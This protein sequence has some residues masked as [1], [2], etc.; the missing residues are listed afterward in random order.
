MTRQFGLPNGLVP[1][2]RSSPGAQAG[3]LRDCASIGVGFP[4]GNLWKAPREPGGSSSHRTRDHRFTKA[5]LCQAELCRQNLWG[6]L[7]ARPRSRYGLAVET[8]REQQAVNETPGARVVRVDVEPA[9]EV[10]QVGAG[11]GAVRPVGR[12]DRLAARIVGPELLG[13]RT[14]PVLQAEQVNP[15]RLRVERLEDR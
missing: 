8:A 12:E 3:G 15:A 2:C 11:D 5:L 13:F 1:N 6:R 4:S 10:R 7:P 14:A 9:V